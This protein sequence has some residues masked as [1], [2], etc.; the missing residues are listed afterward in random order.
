M[1]NKLEAC[2]TCPA[3]G[4]LMEK[5]QELITNHVGDFS[6][7][8]EVLLRDYLTDTEKFDTNS[9]QTEKTCEQ[10]DRVADKAT[11]NV[12][13]SIIYLSQIESGI[14]FVNTISCAKV[15]KPT[16]CQRIDAVWI[17]LSKIRMAMIKDIADTH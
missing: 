15:E 1:K 9:L 12:S 10:N 17:I 3:A 14:D 11:R 16:D 2:E 13:L 4:G 8:G 7:S 5:F 6:Q